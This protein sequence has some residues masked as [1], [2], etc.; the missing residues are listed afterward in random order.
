MTIL[1][2]LWTPTDHAVD[3][4]TEQYIVTK[5]IMLRMTIYVNFYIYTVLWRT[6]FSLLIYILCRMC[7]SLIMAPVRQFILVS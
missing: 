7:V 5:H 2:S 1:D 4:N 6:A 3:D